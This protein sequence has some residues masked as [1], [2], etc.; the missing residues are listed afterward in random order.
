MHFSTKSTFSPELEY[1]RRRIDFRLMRKLQTIYSK[2]KDF[3]DF[4]SKMLEIWKVE[5]ESLPMVDRAEFAYLLAKGLAY[6]SNYKELLEL[7]QEDV[8]P[9]ALSWV[10]YAANITGD[11]ALAKKLLNQALEQL[12]YQEDA[13]VEADILVVKAFGQFLEGKYSLKSSLLQETVDLLSENA[14]KNRTQ[15]T[16]QANIFGFLLIISLQINDYGKSNEVLTPLSQAINVIDRTGGDRLI[17][18][19]IKNLEGE[20][21][22]ILN[23]LPAAHRS[24]SE[25]LALGEAVSNQI[26]ILEAQLGIITSEIEDGKLELA[27][28]KIEKILATAYK[29]QI[30]HIIFSLILKLGYI[31]L[32]LGS[33]KAFHHLSQAYNLAIF[34]QN[35]VQLLE[36]TYPYCQLLQK[37]GRLEKSVEILEKTFDEV[38]H[39]V[40]PLMVK[41]HSLHASF[42]SKLGESDKAI[43]IVYKISS[44]L[45][46]IREKTSDIVMIEIYLN[47]KTVFKEMG[48]IEEVINTYTIIITLSKKIGN[49]KIL[50]SSLAE[51]TEFSIKHNYFDIAESYLQETIQIKQEMGELSD[52]S[53]LYLRLGE[54]YERKDKTNKAI[55][56]YINGIQA[57]EGKDNLALSGTILK[58]LTN[59][60]LKHQRYEGAKSTLKMLSGVAKELK[61]PELDFY[62]VRL[63]T[64]VHLANKE[65][66]RAFK[67]VNEGI[68]KA[69]SEKNIRK[70][71]AFRLTRAK[72][73]YAKYLKNPK[74]EILT[75]IKPEIDDLIKNSSEYITSEEELKFN[76]FILGGLLLSLNQDTIDDGAKYFSKAQYLVNKRFEESYAQVIPILSRIK[77]WKNNNFIE[78]EKGEKELKTDLIII[79]DQLFVDISLLLS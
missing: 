50:I 5:K 31:Q 79:I 55:E 10:A 17:K 20:A 65:I 69:K 66:E 11:F 28:R 41:C 47:L 39:F 16:Q 37:T 23:N 27:V 75:L 26:V 18:G 40:H 48:L 51:A 7:E 8:P 74:K 32:I 3:S 14:K 36:V 61:D 43:S 34:G 9:G 78:K 58:A 46:E 52:V 33:E 63:S 60:Y 76:L 59:L 44:M 13:M 72:I 49:N 35:K 15:E 56:V 19:M 62:V 21:Y 54:L 42:L 67:G 29:F 12:K 30:K 70:E 57:S 2:E 6:S 68:K 71:Y 1:H 77:I 24:F 45:P 4:I 73:L 53:L 64:T 38:Q 25:A 22:L